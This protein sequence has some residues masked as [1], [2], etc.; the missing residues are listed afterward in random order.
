M[1]YAGDCGANIA[2]TGLLQYKS[3]EKPAKEPDFYQKWR[4]DEVEV[5]WIKDK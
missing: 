2:W 3:G 5:N 1:E 4:T